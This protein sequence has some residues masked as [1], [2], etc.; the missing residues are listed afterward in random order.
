ML[1][2]RT[3]TN[4]SG[5]AGA[6][7]SQLP[8]ELHRLALAIM[9][10]AFMVA[11]DMTMVNVALHT[12]ARDFTTSVTTIQWVVTGYLLALAMVIPLTGWAIERFGARRSWVASLAMFLAG[13]ALC[14]LAWSPGSLI[15]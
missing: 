10:G 13:S 9:P 12:L 6:N 3:P 7:S 1:G 15:A 11:L 4:T 8:P 14:G 5:A 2:S